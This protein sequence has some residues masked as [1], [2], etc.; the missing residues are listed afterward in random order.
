MQRLLLGAIEQY[1]E[2]TRNAF[3]CL[4]LTHWDRGPLGVR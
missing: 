1:R 2:I 3:P 4:N